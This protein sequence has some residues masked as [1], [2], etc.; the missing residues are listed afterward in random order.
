[1]LVLDRLAASGFDVF[2]ARPTVRRSDALGL[3]WRAMRWSPASS[4]VHEP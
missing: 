4:P 3:A 1:M 2:N